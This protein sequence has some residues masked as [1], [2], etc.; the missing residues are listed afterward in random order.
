[1]AQST[2]ENDEEILTSSDGE[3]SYQH[4]SKLLDGINTDVLDDQRKEL[5]KTL[6]EYADVFSK[7]ELDLGEKSLAAHQI[8]TGDARPMGQTLQR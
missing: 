4:L 7:G 2:G 3:Q 5:I 8:D 6:R 1:L